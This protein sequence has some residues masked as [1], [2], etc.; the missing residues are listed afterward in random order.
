[1]PIFGPKSTHLKKCWNL[2]SQCSSNVEDLGKYSYFKHTNKTEREMMSRHWTGERQRR[3]FLLSV[4]WLQKHRR[5]GVSLFLCV[6]SA[7]T[8]SLSDERYS[9]TFCSL[10]SS[11]G[12]DNT[13]RGLTEVSTT[14]KNCPFN[15]SAG[16]THLRSHTDVWLFGKHLAK[17]TSGLLTRHR[18]V[19]M[20]RQ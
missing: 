16:A 1:M 6:F 12:A 18:D 3:G 14:F 20:S 15:V 4:Q 10:L 9:H 2:S 13:S 11:S 8:R 5:Q 17:A 7:Q 19:I